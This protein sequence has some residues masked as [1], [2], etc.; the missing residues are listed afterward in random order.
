MRLYLEA[1]S[2][3]KVGYTPDWLKVTFYEN[4]EQMKLTLDIQGDID[5]DK[6]CLSC[7]CKGNLIPWVLYNCENGDEIDLYSMTDEQVEKIFPDERIAKI[8][9]GSSDHIIG[10]Y[11][12]TNGDCEDEEILKRAEDDTVSDGKGSFEMFTS[13]VKGEHHYH[14]EFEFETELNV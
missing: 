11:P 4:G 9:C 1:E 5:Y 3:N 12:V 7:R 14:K 6:G 13:D 8:I 2:K 10:I